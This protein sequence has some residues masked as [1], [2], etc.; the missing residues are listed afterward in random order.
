MQ[1][2]EDITNRDLGGESRQ[3]TRLSRRRE[4]L[5]KNGNWSSEQLRQGIAAVDN[6]MSMKRAAETYGI[7]YSSFRDWY[8]GKTRTRL[9]GAQGVL[10]AEEEEQIVKYLIDMC[11]RDYGL[12][13]TQLKMKVYEIT[14]N[15]WTPFKHGIH[16]SGW[17]RWWR[18]RHPELTLRGSQVLEATRAKGLSQSNVATFYDNLEQFYSDYKYPL[19]HVWN[20]DKYGAHIGI[21]HSFTIHHILATRTVLRRHFSYNCHMQIY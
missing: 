20:C 15:R 9:R 6:G 16:G 10:T 17:M 5:K 21:Y 13:P 8:Y 1:V 4:K 3:S 18:H 7:P 2:L 11:D 12:S 19:E 14:K